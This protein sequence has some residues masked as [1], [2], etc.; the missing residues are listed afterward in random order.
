MIRRSL[1]NPAAGLAAAL[2]AGSLCVAAAPAGAASAS[3]TAR[4]ATPS[5]IASIGPWIVVANRGPSTLSVL[6]ADGG[7]FLRSV[8][9]AQL[10]V[11]APSAIVTVTARGRRLAFVGGLGGRVAELAV[12]ARGGGVAIERLGVL[13]LT[14]CAA[15]A[16]TLLA[17]DGRGQV[18]EACSTGAM[19]VFTAA[20]G[21][22]DR[23][24]PA[25][26]TRLTDAAGLAVLGSTVYATNDAA[27]AVP[28]EVVA[29]SLVTGRRVLAVSN[30]T[31]A[32]NAFSTPVGI[33]SDGTNLWVANKQGSTVDEL[34]GGSLA[35][36]GTSSTNLTAPTVVLATPKFTWV[37][38]ASVNGSSSMVTQFYDV[39][40]AIA[41]PWMMCNSNGPY[42]FG[43]PSG[44]TM[45]GGM[46][47]VANAADDL[48]DQ[49][50]ATT[51]ELVATYT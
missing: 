36:L 6:A 11:T 43:D 16:T 1:L 39:G 20:T 48:I 12:A 3:S 9:H 35:L 19:A 2:V 37:S 13:Q 44:F 42:Q 8:S 45:H 29:I 25:S 22:L 10:G 50:N 51:G 18:V 14:G 4:F 33:A 5:A 28:D 34:A 47:W 40:H 7:T 38:S 41:S 23:S 32:S 15:R 26:A 31:N 21:H 27:G 17:T 49:M 24:I 30:A 46:L